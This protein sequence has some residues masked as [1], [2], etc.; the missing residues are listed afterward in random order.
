[1]S[2][3]VLE[4]PQRFARACLSVGV[5]LA[6][7]GAVGLVD[8]W[9][10]LPLAGLVLLVAALTML[11][12]SESGEHLG[13]EVAST[14][15]QS[16]GLA[17]SVLAEVTA[18]TQAGKVAPTVRPPVPPAPAPEPR[19][20]VRRFELPA[21]VGATSVW[22]VGD[23]NGWSHR[24]TPMRREG[25]QFVVEVELE[26]GRS[27]RYRYLLDDGRWENDWHADRYVPN[28]FGGDDCVAET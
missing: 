10:I 15:E 12:V 4:S 13:P 27:H 3:G 14:E 22:L 2:S 1:M 18:A 23:F 6:I 5:A 26:R 7:V 16:P 21:T 11:V 9:L 28:A 20:V 24:A 17:P 25:D 19:R 8:R